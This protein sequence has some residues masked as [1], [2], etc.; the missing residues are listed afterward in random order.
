MS[1]PFAIPDEGYVDLHRH[2]VPAVDDGVKSHEEGVALIRGLREVGFSTVV[3]TPHI[4]TAMFENRKD[5]LQVAHAA[6]VEQVQGD[7]SLPALGLGAEHFFDEGEDLLRELGRRWPVYVHGLGLSLGTPEPLDAETLRRFAR[8]AELTGAEW[9]SEHV[10][11]TRAGEVDLVINT[12]YG[13]FFKQKTAYEILHKDA[14]RFL[15]KLTRSNAPWAFAK[16]EPFRTIA[17]LELLGS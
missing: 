9:V 3:A 7:D 10:A 13:I 15:L 17:A 1:V 4:R 8:V 5:P 6:F 14:N 11:F 16:G 2:H 12:P